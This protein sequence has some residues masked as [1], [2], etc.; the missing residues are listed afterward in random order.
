M[1][2]LM[3][4]FLSRSYFNPSAHL[5]RYG[6][7]ASGAC[8]THGF[9]VVEGNLSGGVF[10]TGEAYREDD[11][12]LPKSLRHM[13]GEWAG[14]DGPIAPGVPNQRP[15]GAGEAAASKRRLVF[16]PPLPPSPSSSSPS[17]SSPFLLPVQWSIMADVGRPW[18]TLVDHG[19]PWSTMV[20]HG[21][22]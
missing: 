20:D 12:P 15:K 18:S 9:I 7:V 17:F 13:L 21:R 14:G 4:N 1:R 22:P 5:R 8:K 3:C 19:R 16:P 11:L 10:S 6:E 2:V